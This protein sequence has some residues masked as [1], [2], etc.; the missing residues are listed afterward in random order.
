MKEFILT[1]ILLLIVGCSNNPTKIIWSDEFNYTG[2]P[3]ASKW[4]HQ[5]IPP[6]SYGWHNNELQ[7]YIDSESTSY[8]SEGTLKIKALRQD[9]TY[10]GDTK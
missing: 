3:D 10:E 9:Y 5:V 6:N 7:H 4:H 8:V 2:R 1:P